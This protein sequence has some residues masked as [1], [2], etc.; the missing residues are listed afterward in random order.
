MPSPKMEGIPKW[1][2]LT[3]KSKGPLCMIKMGRSSFV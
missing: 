1:R 2:G 3:D